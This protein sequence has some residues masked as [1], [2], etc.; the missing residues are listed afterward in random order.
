MRPEDLTVDYKKLMRMTVHDRINMARSPLG[1]SYLGSLTPTQYA[2]LFPS[3]Y[4]TMVPSYSAIQSASTMGGGG[5]GGYGGG[6]TSYPKGA[7]EAASSIPSTTPSPTPSSTIKPGWLVRFEKEVLNKAGPKTSGTIGGASLKAVRARQMKELDDPKV[8]AAVLARVEIETG[9]QG[10]EAQRNWMETLFN[11]AA[12]AKL[13]LYDAVANGSNHRYYPRKDDRRWQSMAGSL[14]G[15]LESKFTNQLNEVGSG[16]NET[17]YATDNAS[18][19]LAKQRYSQYGGTWKNGEL[20][21]N[22]KEVPAYGNWAAQQRKADSEEATKVP[23]QQA[24]ADDA[25][26]TPLGPGKEKQKTFVGYEKMDPREFWAQRNPNKADIKNVD[27]RLLKIRMM[28]AVKFEEEH[29]GKRVEIYGSASGKRQSSKTGG[30]QHLSGRALDLAIYEIGPNGQKINMGGAYGNYPNFGSAKHGGMVGTAKAAHLYDRLNE[31]DELARVYM[32]DVVGDNSYGFGIRIGTYFSGEYF[33][34]QMHVDIAGQLDKQGLSVG[35]TAAGSVAYGMAEDYLKKMGISPNSPEGKELLTGVLEKYGGTKEGVVEAAKAT[36]GGGSLST[37]I[38]QGYENLPEGLRKEIDAMSV[39]D[40][41][42]VFKL[43]QK[44]QEVGIDPISGL[45]TAFE[46]SKNDPTAVVQTITESPPGQIPEVLSGNFEV[47][48]RSREQL[49][50]KEVQ[51]TKGNRIVSLDFN[52]TPG[53]KG[54]EVVIP[55]DATDEEKAAAQNYVSSV[56]KY[57]EDRGYK[58]YPIRGVRRTSANKRGVPGFIHTEPFFST[59]KEAVDIISKDPAG[60]ASVVATTLGALPGTKFIPP[61]MEESQGAVIPKGLSERQF[62]LDKL[63]PELKKIKEASSDAAET[64]LGPTVPAQPSATATPVVSATAPSVRFQDM[65]LGNA[66]RPNF[67]DAELEAINL[68]PGAAE[69]IAKGIR[70]NPLASSFLAS[71]SAVRAGVLDKSPE[72]KNFS[73]LP[74]DK[75]QESL[76]ALRE[77]AAAQATPAPEAPKPAPTTEQTP[78]ATPEAKSA[79]PASTAEKVPEKSQGGSMGITPGENVQIYKN[80]KLAA[81]SNDRE[82]YSVENGQLNIEPA[83]MASDPQQMIDTAIQEYD[84]MQQSKK[85]PASDNRMVQQSV[86]RGRDRIAYD[87]TNLRSPSPSEMRHLTQTKADPYRNGTGF[88]LA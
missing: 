72:L 62:A 21:Y 28:A 30:S 25:A 45:T 35:G 11:R 34:D 22:N 47:L 7:V 2:Q 19:T 29:P 77:K 26:E 60:Y 13:S 33:T 42:N 18:S 85:E 61:H 58:N 76:K 75:Q 56:K 54:V 24:P 31:Y 55:D 87:V 88:N 43:M 38:P 50:Q 73:T 46:A 69:K 1:Q 86:P 80:G 40:R 10:P 32:K 71:P 44:A 41:N 9:G 39:F 79:E 8:R 78:T 67:T 82:L 81:V 5:G 64:P 53:A 84:K 52:A 23:K 20:F 74:P 59:D 16:S 14:P 37:E 27:S 36:F 68:T 49:S 57:F 6:G 4:K 15:S 65:D 17:N 63:I 3:Y 51:S 48:D 70:E 66:K 12:A 83:K